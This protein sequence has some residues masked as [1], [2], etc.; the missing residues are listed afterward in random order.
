MNKTTQFLLGILVVIAIILGGFALWLFRPVEKKDPQ[1][2][3]PTSEPSAYVYKIEDSYLQFTLDTTL[4][5]KVTGKFTIIGEQVVFIPEGD[6]WRLSTT[7]LI[8]GESADTGDAIID[9]IIIELFQ[10]RIYQGK[11]VGQSQEIITDLTIPQ[12][13]NLIGQLEL[14]G[15][16]QPF[17]IP[18]EFEIVDDVFRTRKAEGV[19]DISLYG[20]NTGLVRSTLLDAS[21]YV[22]AMLLADVI[23]APVLPTTEATAEA[24]E[25]AE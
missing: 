6:G 7:L 2:V 1:L 18:I 11:F 12:T 3:S 13:I 5:G 20:V 17:S 15:Q 23:P 25:P 21:I 14:I 4:R 19:L 24:T 8:D 9:G 10:G 22:E 16:I